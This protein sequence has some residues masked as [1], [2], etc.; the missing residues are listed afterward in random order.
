MKV[1][2]IYLFVKTLQIHKVKTRNNRKRR[3]HQKKNAF[4]CC[5][6]KNVRKGKMTSRKSGR[7]KIT[8]VEKEQNCET[9]PILIAK[10]RR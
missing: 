1:N 6:T 4:V 10:W 7:G 9:S 2:F 8:R 5:T 3:R